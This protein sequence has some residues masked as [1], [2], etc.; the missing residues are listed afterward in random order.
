MDTLTVFTSADKNYEMFVLPYICSVLLS[1]PN[2]TRVEVCLEEAAAFVS[3]NGEAL[4][5]LDG[6]FAGQFGLS[7]ADF[8]SLRPHTVRFVTTPNIVS[9]YVYIGDIDIIVTEEIMTPHR[10]KML[11][12]GLPYSNIKR[13]GKTA[14]S[15]LHFSKWDAY[16]PISPTTPKQRINL[17]EGYLWDLV[18]A[19]G[20]PTPDPDERFRPI[21]GLHLSLNRDPR[22]VRPTWGNVRDKSTALAYARLRSHPVWQQLSALFDKRF[23][24][25]TFILDS[26]LAARYVDD[27]EPYDHAKDLSLEEMISK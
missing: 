4:T 26:M 20:H 23:Q 12:T 2:T 7:E 8:S 18:T 5:I 11:E 16:Y 17:D 25:L 21:H 19:R 13:P 24:R 9:D 3:T 6:V 10:Q 27:I 1:N 15:G 22:T 14:L